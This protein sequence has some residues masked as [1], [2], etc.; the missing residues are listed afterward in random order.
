MR[1]MSIDIETYSSEDLTKTG[2]YRYSEA[3][4]FEILL[5]AY[6]FDDDDTVHQIDLAC[7]EKLPESIV[8]A[9]TDPDIVKTAYNANFERVCISVYLGLTD[10]LPPEQWRCT[11]VASSEL[12][13][14]QNLAGV[15]SAFGLSEQKDTRG[16]ALINYFS[17]PCKPTKSNGERTRN[18][19]EHDMEKWKAYKEYN[20]QDVVVERAIKEKLARFPLKDSEQKLWEID[21]RILDRGVG[22]D[23]VLT[24]NA[25]LFNQIHKE[26]RMEQLQ[27][28]TN[29]RNVNSVAQLKKWVESRTG[30]NVESLDKKAVKNLLETS[31][32]DV[33]KS[34]LLLR[35]ELAK[36]SIAKYEAVKRSMCQDKRVRGIL[37]FYGANR[38][39]RWAGRILQVQNLP[40]NHL[41]DLD[42]AREL[43]RSGD[44]DLFQTLFSVP[45]TLSELI[46]TMLVPSENCRFIVS[47]FSAIE[48]RVIAFLADEI[49]RLNVFAEGGD[50]YCASASQMFKVPVVKHGVNGHLRQKGKIAELALGYGGGVSALTSMGALE[51]GI[52]EEELQPLVDM[53]RGSNPA[54]TRF[55]KTVE[56]AAMDAIKGKPSRIRHGISFVREAGILFVGLPSGRRIAYVK[57]EI[58]ENRFGS[59]SIHYMGVDQT[60]RTWTKLETWG[61]KLVENIVQAVARDCLAES[62]IRLEQKGYRTVFHVHDEAV[63]DVPEGTGSVEDVTSLMGKPISWAP[64]LP[65]TAAGYECRYYKKDD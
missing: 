53:W 59:P 46:R 8:E 22:V 7:G 2:V 49:W 33:L 42:L 4:D 5:F 11:A 6:A 30:E 17:K 29:L 10:F 25:I 1:E 32:D 52:P 28:I 21:Q 37:Q 18:L 41:A 9:L 36:T 44:Y 48:A 34:A 62:I 50:I 27:N 56:R 13:L 63:L 26:D 45:Q 40:Q 24:Q 19:P 12:G 39:G 16:K 51:M 14:P 64:G 35:K 20:I 31:Q 15:A 58:G 43:V 61:G 54:I 60:K 23:E 3:P 38:T 47:D 55:W 65:L 57:S